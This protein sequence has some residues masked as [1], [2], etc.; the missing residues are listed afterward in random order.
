M[1]TSVHSN[2]PLVPADVHKKYSKR[3]MGTLLGN[4]ISYVV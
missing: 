4:R 2:M 3:E 1:T